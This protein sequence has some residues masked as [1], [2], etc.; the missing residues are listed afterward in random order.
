[1][2]NEVRKVALKSIPF[3]R[4]ANAK[5]EPDCIAADTCGAVVIDG[6]VFKPL[7]FP[8]LAKTLDP[9]LDPKVARELCTLESEEEKADR[10]EKVE[11]AK[12]IVLG[13]FTE[14]QRM[15]EID[16]K[17][18]GVKCKT[19]EREAEENERKLMDETSDVAVDTLVAERANL[20][21]VIAYKKQRSQGVK[22]ISADA[23]RTRFDNFSNTLNYYISKN[24]DLEDLQELS[25]DRELLS[26]ITYYYTK[27]H[28]VSI[29]DRALET[30]PEMRSV[31][32]KHYFFDVAGKNTAYDFESYSGLLGDLHAAKLGP[33]FDGFSLEQMAELISPG[34]TAGS[35]P[36]IRNWFLSESN[37]WQGDEGKARAERA[38]AWVLEYGEKV[39]CKE[40]NTL[41]LDRIRQINW[42]VNLS[43]VHGL[44][45]MLALC[46]A[47]DD[48]LKAIRLGLEELGGKDLVKKLPRYY[49]TRAGMWSERTSSGRKLIDDVTDDLISLM[50]TS[51]PDMFETQKEV[52]GK[53]IGEGSLIPK[54][55]R[56]FNSWSDSY[57]LL[58]T[59]CLR[60]SEMSIYDALKRRCPSVCGWDLDQVKEW[61]IRSRD[62]WQG[63]SGK[64]LFRKAF[65]Y[66]LGVSGLG[67]FKIEEGKLSLSFTKVDV[68]EWF[69]R[70]VAGE[71]RNDLKRVI[72]AR[73]LSG[74]LK[75]S[76]C[77]DKTSRALKVLFNYPVNQN[78]PQPVK[79]DGS[80][81]N[82]SILTRERMKLLVDQAGGTF[83]IE[84]GD[85]KNKT[86][87]REEIDERVKKLNAVLV[88]SVQNPFDRDGVSFVKEDVVRVEKD[89]RREGSSLGHRYISFDVS[90]TKLQ[91]I[92]E[93]EDCSKKRLLV[94][95]STALRSQDIDILISK[96]PENQ[97]RDLLR[98]VRDDLVDDINLSNDELRKNVKK[99]INLMLTY[100]SGLMTVNLDSKAIYSGASLVLKYA[101]STSIRNLQYIEVLHKTFKFLAD[102]LLRN[103]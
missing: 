19:L 31:L 44:K 56:E 72:F 97:F 48:T 94:N 5:S 88:S 46:P 89:L 25:G 65:A 37:M 70:V 41:D 103:V 24:S 96:M 59:D 80:P 63:D 36:L 18:K 45:G 35:N 92:L 15:D 16:S 76:V 84:F 81:V 74:G 90:E 20:E 64:K 91:R 54:K 93:G 4:S 98:I 9:K 58:A 47:A 83:T 99:V 79:S 68:D 22:F 101:P 6:G 30:L 67:K 100:K 86:I 13:L 38:M 34:S 10:L 52:A 39:Y 50:R 21:E 62:M 102:V 82:R 40:G 51:H 60:G 49:I 75:Y 17:Y 95:L 87:S 2:S 69:D 14:V 27:D 7:M 28:L 1:M 3:R 12:R 66:N 78:L 8:A 61:E 32:A 23:K 77:K 55:V 71:Y 43:R 85:I 53:P 26:L 42:A 11:K 57:N 73:R 33:V 29:P